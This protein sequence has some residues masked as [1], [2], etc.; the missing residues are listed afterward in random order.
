MNS[1]AEFGGATRYRFLAI[2]E[3]PEG[4]DNRPPAVRGLTGS[5][6]GEGVIFT[7]CYKYLPNQGSQRDARGVV[8]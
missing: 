5:F 4:A 7:P 6:V 3:K 2:D 1:N 8:D